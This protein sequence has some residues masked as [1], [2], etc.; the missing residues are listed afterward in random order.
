[1]KPV[2]NKVKNKLIPALEK[3]VELFMENCEE[4]FDVIIS[5]NKKKLHIYQVNF[6]NFNEQ[7]KDYDVTANENNTTD[8]KKESETAKSSGKSSV[9]SAICQHRAFMNQQKLE[10][11]DDTLSKKTQTKELV[12]T[13][14]ENPSDDFSGN[15][16]KLDT[17]LMKALKY[18]YPS[19]PP[20]SKPEFLPKGIVLP[21]LKESHKKSNNDFVKSPRIS[22]APKSHRRR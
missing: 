2:S 11:K 13:I 16:Y 19:P 8:S 6:R 5:K 17:I 14:R 18:R 12:I 15:R 22:I 20:L 9:L 3:I 10:E 21:Y 4:D 1:M 7:K